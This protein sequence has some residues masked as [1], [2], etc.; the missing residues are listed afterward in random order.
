MVDNLVLNPTHPER[1][2]SRMYVP[3]DVGTIGE[4]AFVVVRTTGSAQSFVPELRK[5]VTNVD[6]TL[7][8]GLVTQ[9]GDLGGVLDSMIAAGSLAFGIVVASGLLLCAA[10]VFS[11]MSFSVTQRR[12]EIGIRAA[13]G[14]MPGQV[15]RRVLGRSLKQ[16]AIGVAVGL[17]IVWV[18]PEIN[19]DGIIIDAT[20]GPTA[21]V[22]LVMVVVGLLA[23]IG[24]ARQGL[25]IQPT[26]AMREG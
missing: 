16:V 1:V 26:E 6:P 7:T 5:T 24:P 13:L 9:L 22:A 25:G 3:L 15:L 8:L 12:R 10:G 20:A 19:A 11:M 21:F 23:A 4:G 14:A 2:E 18:T 17:A